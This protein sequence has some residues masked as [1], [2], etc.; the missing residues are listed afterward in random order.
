[1]W[2][3]LIREEHGILIFYLKCYMEP[4]GTQSPI[5]EQVKSYLETKYKLLKYEGIDKASTIISEVITDLIIA[6]LLLITFV[7]FCTMLAI[8]AA[9]LLHSTWEGFGCVTLLYLLIALSARLLQVRLQNIFMKRMI[10][11]L[12]RKRNN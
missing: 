11:K 4:T 1:M 10:E 2:E 3:S 12:F 6:L 7:F 8:F 9:H 5:I